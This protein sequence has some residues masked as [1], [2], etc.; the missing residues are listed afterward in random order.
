ML[1]RLTISGLFAAAVASVV[2]SSSAA[3]AS[4]DNFVPSSASVG[5]GEV[6]Q[7]RVDPS[8]QSCTRPT[9]QVAPTAVFR[10]TIEG[11]S[12][13]VVVGPNDVFRTDFTSGLLTLSVN[14][15]QS[16]GSYLIV[17]TGINECEG[18]DA[19]AS[20]VVTGIETTTTATTTT[21]TTTT[22]ITAQV[23]PTTAA[24]TTTAAPA[25]LPATGR[26]TDGLVW[27]ALAVSL[28]G[29]GLVAVA[30]RRS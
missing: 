19:T 9:E 11:A 4:I 14:A 7:F 27:I 22:T 21:T 13:A 15:P 1:R 25:T 10:W 17:W 23:A 2:F 8:D 28:L 26:S 3:A 29:G 16:P 6:I 18:D 30:A 20:F 12:G 24:T 5:P